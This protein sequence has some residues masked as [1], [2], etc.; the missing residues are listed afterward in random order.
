MLEDNANELHILHNAGLYDHNTL[1]SEM[2]SHCVF[3]IDIEKLQNRYLP[4][5]KKYAMFALNELNWYYGTP[6]DKGD[7]EGSIGL[8]MSP[9]EDQ[10]LEMKLEQ[11]RRL[12]MLQEKPNRSRSVIEIPKPTPKDA[13]STTTPKAEVATAPPSLEPTQT[14]TKIVMPEMDAAA[15]RKVKIATIVSVIIIL[16]LAL[17]PAVLLTFCS[18]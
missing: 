5:L 16:S 11:E 17:I 2:K 8:Y 3:Q 10:V 13:P 1:W 9:A 15:Q 6:V 7:K 18:R 12:K 14:P 4:L